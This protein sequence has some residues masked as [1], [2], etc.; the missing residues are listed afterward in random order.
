MTGECDA[1]GSDLFIQGYL[2]ADGEANF[3]LICPNC[4]QIEAPHDVIRPDEGD[5]G[6][7]PPAE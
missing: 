4:D 5:L 2:G 6:E 1:C 7:D 3:A